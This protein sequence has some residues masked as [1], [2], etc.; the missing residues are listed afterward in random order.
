MSSRCDKRLNSVASQNRLVHVEFKLGRNDEY[1]ILHCVH[2]LRQ[3]EWL[4]GECSMPLTTHAL[5][6]NTEQ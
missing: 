1:G 2:I 6:V 5:G 3:S 4:G